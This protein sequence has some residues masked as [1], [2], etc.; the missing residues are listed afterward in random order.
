MSPGIDFLYFYDDGD[1]FPRLGI[2]LLPKIEF[3]YRHYYNLEKRKNRNKH[4]TNNSGCYLSGAI[5]LQTILGAQ[6]DNFVSF[7][8]GALWG[9]QNNKGPV[10]VNFEIGPGLL[11]VFPDNDYDLAIL[12]KLKFGFLLDK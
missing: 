8:V 3:S 12:L 1:L 11:I 2:G 5:G 9:V 6:F 10:T 7:A 4:Y